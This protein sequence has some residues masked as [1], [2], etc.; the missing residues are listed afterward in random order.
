MVYWTYTVNGTFFSKMDLRA[1]P[2]DTQQLK[3]VAIM[4]DI[5]QDTVTEYG[6]GLN[7]K[8]AAARPFRGR[9]KFH[10][11]LSMLYNENFVESDSWIVS[12][13]VH[14]WGSKTDEKRR[15]NGD[16]VRPEGDGGRRGNGGWRREAPGCA[17]GRRGCGAAAAAG[18]DARAQADGQGWEGPGN[19][20][21]TRAQ[22]AGDRRENPARKPGAQAYGLR[23]CTWAWG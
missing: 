23:C 15:A 3:V 12:K 1:F 19:P 11:D 17:R 9:V 10:Q 13:H 16:G 22:P 8:P 20:R 18:G 2:F 14:A 21:E 7:P 4:W 5:S 6:N